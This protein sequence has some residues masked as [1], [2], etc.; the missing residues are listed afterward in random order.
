MWHIIRTA[1]LIA[2]TLIFDFF[3]WI[4]KYSRHPEKY[5]MEK[6]YQR[7]RNLIVRIN[8][9]LR[10]ETIVEGQ[11]NR[12]KEIACYYV[13]HL[14]AV[15]PL[16][17]FEAIEEPTAFLAK[18]EVKKMPF[19]GRIFKGANGLFLKRDDLK[20][21]LKVMMKVEASLKN[22]ECNWV[23]YPEGTRNKDPM[24]KL[25]EFHKGTFRSAMKANVPLVPVVSYGSFRALNLKHNYKK[26]PTY[27]KFLKP[28]YPEEYNGKTTDEIASMVQS[29]IQKELSFNVK[30]LD[31][32][33]MSESKDSYYRFNAIK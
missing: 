7:T 21:Q 20:Q 32:K 18:I 28:I 11:E 6:R 33:R 14:A 27:V 29:R 12:P 8:H 23:I 31:H 5:P 25:L 15:D 19:V 24:N 3:A 9:L 26:Y 30:A 2:P 16:L 4:L 1:L 13:N 10:L 22:K 17:I